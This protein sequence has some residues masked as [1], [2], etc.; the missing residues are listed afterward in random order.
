MTRMQIFYNQKK[1]NR[2]K[3]CIRNKTFEQKDPREFVSPV[4]YLRL[5]SRP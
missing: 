3:S 5:K 4:I 2:K 1:K